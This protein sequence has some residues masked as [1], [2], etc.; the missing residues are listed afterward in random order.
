MFTTFFCIRRFIVAMSTVFLVRQ[1]I[2]QIYLNTYTSLS[3]LFFYF[4]VRPMATR[5]Q[6]K[7]ELLNETFT[8]FSNYFL[9]LFSDFILELE[10]RYDIGFKA[11]GL[12]IMIIACNIFL[13]FYDIGHGLINSWKAK[14]YMQML[15]KFKKKEEEMDNFLFMHFVKTSNIELDPDA[16]KYMRAKITNDYSFKQKIDKIDF[17]FR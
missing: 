16:K 1:L 14:K 9:I 17:I 3:L 10:V 6:N 15:E 5:Q 4:Q 7:I 11:V 2:S 8:M 13:V 12:T